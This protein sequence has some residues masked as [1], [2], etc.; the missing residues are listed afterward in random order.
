MS[1]AKLLNAVAEHRRRR[2]WSQEELA[3]KCGV[4]R[5][6]VSAIE[7]GRLVPSTLAA[8]GLARAFE[9]R[10]EA[11]F[12][13]P[14]AEQRYAE[15]AWPPPH[16]PSRFWQAG[17]KSRTL[18]YPVEMTALGVLPHDGVLSDPTRLPKS[19]DPRKTLV[20]AGCDPAAP[21]LAFELLT[22]FNIRLL[23]LVRPSLQA[24]DLLKRGLVHA[25]GVHLSGT[26]GRSANQQIV[27]K[28][29]GPG[30]RI[31][32]VAR[33]QEG[34]AVAPSVKVKTIRQ[35]LASRIRWVN[36]EE[37]SG[38]RR[39][40]DHLLAGRAAKPR[41]YD[42]VAS[43]HRGVVETIRSGWAQAGVCVR[44]AAEEAGLGFLRVE[45]E[46][47]ELCYSASL[48]GDPRIQALVK[49]VRLRAYRRALGELPGYSVSRTGE[50]RSAGQ[51]RRNDRS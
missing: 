31:L 19:G 22:T 21:L 20:I 2:G 36:R 13:L 17:V 37:G 50:I 6:E 47:Y 40:L 35:L 48:E 28:L 23:P 33:W 41:G 27:Q 29:L 25:A 5:A 39:C 18:L 3:G 45:D 11:L 49:T 34:A 46:D 51:R 24:L 15:W 30:Y 44:L 10:V 4:S 14:I 38:A 42:H 7:T 16:A 9:S 1:E 12:G 43:D 8:L 32:H 26:G